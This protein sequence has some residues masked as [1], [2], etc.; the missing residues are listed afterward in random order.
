MPS[1]LIPSHFACT[2]SFYFRSVL[3]FLLTASS[4]VRVAFCQEER[5]T[6]VDEHLIG[7]LDGASGT[8]ALFSA[9]G[10]SI[11]TAGGKEARVWNARTLKPET[12]PLEHKQPVKSAALSPDGRSVVTASGNVAT[13]WNART[14]MSL[15]VLPHVDRV[16]DAAFSPDGKHVATACIDKHARIF[17]AATGELLFDLEHEHP[18][19]SISFS[20]DG[21]R[22]LAGTVL[23]GIDPARAHWKND[24]LID[25]NQADAPGDAYVWDIQKRRILA[26]YATNWE[27]CK[28]RP[29]FSPDGTRVGVPAG[30]HGS[31]I[32]D[33]TTG[34]RVAEWGYI[35]GVSGN[36]IV[37]FSRDGK[38]FLVAGDD[39]SDAIDA[40]A[41]VLEI[42]T[43]VGAPACSFN[44]V[45]GF[46]PNT[47]LSAADISPDGLLVA[48]ADGGAT[49]V[50]DV[51]TGQC[52]LPIPERKH[53][54]ILIAHGDK[55]C[56]QTAIT[57]SPDGKQIA[58]GFVEVVHGAVEWKPSGKTRTFI[59][60]VPQAKPK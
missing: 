48:L 58:V 15:K 35:C 41:H 4:A 29:L 37:R 50:Y 54:S 28:G 36:T 18:V 51:A 11:L 20:P 52:L 53:A 13:L 31:A 30:A 7:E 8:T 33:A 5:N 40:A 19:R 49:G 60:R 45:K 26:S 12:G 21:T 57:F 46:A 22:L 6:A 23:T 59:W 16:F 56:V 38:R 27:Y 25:I 24:N 9:D 43:Q 10:A 32:M 1:R 47:L 42:A 17:N 2:G 44:D 14:G 3:I 55:S 34:E 39:G